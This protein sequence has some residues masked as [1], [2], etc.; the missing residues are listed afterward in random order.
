MKNR[1]SD[2]K[3][4]DR[5]SER[6]CQKDLARSS[7]RARQHR[8]WQTVTVLGQDCFGSLLEVGCGAGFSAQYLRH[9]FRRYVGI[10]CSADLVALA[11]QTHASNGAKFHAVDIMEFDTRD[12]FDVVLMVGVLHHIT[13][14]GRAMRKIVELT[15]PGGWVLANEPNSA[16]GLWQLLRKT[17]TRLDSD[18]SATQRQ[19][20]AKELHGCFSHAG[21]EEVHVTGQG[22]V[23]TPFAEIILRP[24]FVFAPLAAVAC[25]GDSVLQRML[26]NRMMLRLGWNLV[27]TGRKART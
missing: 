15:R 1:T 12:A 22:L 10:D 19:L 4:F 18:Y 9:R 3:L 26:G 20:N 11:K 23:S 2:T 24:Q 8:L 7:R 25:L 27:T 16:N 17:R 5:I 6:Y 13:D 14:L 21:L